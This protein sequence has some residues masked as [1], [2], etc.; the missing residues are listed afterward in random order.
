MRKS[1]YHAL[2]TA[3]IIFGFLAPAFAEGTNDEARKHL[4]RGMAAIE[5]AKNADELSDAVDEFKKATELAPDMAEAWYNLGSVQSKT[6]QFKDAIASYQRYLTLAPQAKDAA[7]V[8]DEITK[9]EFRMDKEQ[10]VKSHVGT[11]VAEDGTPFNLSLNGNQVV[12]ATSL[13]YVSN[14]DVESTY[15]MVGKVPVSIFIPFR[16]NLSMQGKKLGGVW[17]RPSFKADKCTVPED[18][19]EVTGE[20]Q[21]DKHM[22]ILRY[23]YTKFHASTQMS[24]L[25]DDF[26][27][28]VVAVEKK[29]IEKKFYGP[30]PK[31]GIGVYLDG[32][33]SYFPGGFSM[34]KFGWTGH[35]VVYGLKQDSPAFLAG[36]RDKD[37]ILSIDGAPVASL[38]VVDALTKLRGEP[39]SEVV[40]TLMRNK[41]A[42]APVTVRLKRIAIPNDQLSMN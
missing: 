13:Y 15:T 14:E 34:I 4:V 41:K 19:G 1:F 29:D 17:S 10:R 9:L 33:H 6:G 32:I 5:S 11:W 30:L 3:L 35:L 16:F 12:L 18:G 38:S 42:D 26:C 37:D 36:L 31:G 23:T 20:F 25:T 21:D 7:R 24:V 2:L 22:L 8:K 28:E 39:G 40:L 27:R